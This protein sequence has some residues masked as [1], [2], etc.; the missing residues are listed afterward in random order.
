M[1]DRP[2][3]FIGLSIGGLFLWSIFDL[4]SLTGYPP[5]TVFAVLHGLGWVL[6]GYM[7][8]TRQV[9]DVQHAE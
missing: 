4:A 8:L 7:L 9:G 5:S 3:L 1:N 6:L 2:T